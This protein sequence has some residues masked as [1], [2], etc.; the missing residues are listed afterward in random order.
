MANDPILIVGA[1]IIGLTL[2]QALK[3]RNIPF[4]IYERDPSLASR[5]QGWAITLHWALQYLPALLPPET[6]SAIEDGQVDPEVAKNDTGN[7]LFLDLSTGDVKWRIPPNKRW[8]VNREKLRRA[9]SL[10]IEEHVEWGVRVEDVH[11]TNKLGAEGE[12]E[13]RLI[14]SRR[15]PDT[16]APGEL[17]GTEQ[18]PPGKLII[19]TEGA[20]STIRQFLCPTTYKNTRLPVRFTG[21]ITSFTAE[22]IAPLRAMDPLLFQ[23]CHPETGV[24]LW[25]SMLDTPTEDEISSGSGR[26]KVQLGISWHVKS[27]NDEVPS[28]NADRLANMKR[29]A[30]EFVPFLYDTIQRIPE[31]TEVVEVTLADWG[32]PV[33]DNREGRVTLAGDAAHAMTMYRGEA[34]NHGILDAVHLVEA[35]EKVYAG[36]NSK[37]AIDEYEAEMRERAQAA[38]LLSRQACLDAHDW[39]SLNENSAILKRRALK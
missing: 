19:G 36:K 33:W 3:K 34:C 27:P 39:E 14:Y 13:A 16:T 10:G 28:S 22:E 20:R 38:V 21:V 4:K 8:R 24:Y 35:I 11:V 32:C 37:D 31:G 5:S 1:G 7:F 2:G 17:C 30:E 29:R 18:S 23:G 26:Y 25:F 12:G 9:L 6:L 15:S